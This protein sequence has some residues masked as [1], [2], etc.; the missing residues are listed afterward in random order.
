MAKQ[1]PGYW[2]RYYEEHREQRKA[3]SREYQRAHAGERQGY[4][5]DYYAA[6]KEQ[7]LTASRERRAKNRE[8]VR[9]ARKAEYAANPEK[10]KQHARNWRLANPRRDWDNKLK[11]YGITSNDYDRILSE[12]GGVCAICSG[13]PG[14]KRSYRFHVD[15]CHN[16]GVVRGLLCS[17]C[18]FGIGHF[19]D[20]PE[21]FERVAL[22]L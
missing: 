6:H 2:K 13:G 5:A 17:N 7:A 22:Y 16:T 18:N 9:A 3:E 14:D 10:F 4:L 15:H 11:K 21:R 12:Q 1:P 19:R 20:N 8:A